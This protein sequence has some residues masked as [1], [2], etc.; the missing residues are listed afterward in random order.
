MSIA[1]THF[2]AAVESLSRRIVE[3]EMRS[4]AAA[5]ALAALTRTEADTAEADQRFKEEMDALWVLRRQFWE[6]R[7]AE[8]A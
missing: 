4:T 7:A 5:D 8:S 1:N 3:A 2:E 6:L